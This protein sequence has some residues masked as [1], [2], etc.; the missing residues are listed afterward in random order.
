[1]GGR[2]TYR[3]LSR[4]RAPFQIG[5]HRW[6]H[7][8]K[9]PRRRWISHTYPVWLWGCS[10]L[11]IPSPGPVLHGTKWLLWRPH[12][13]S[14]TFHSWRRIDKGL[15]KRGSTIDHW[16]PRCKG[17]ILWPTPYT[18]ISA[19][20]HT[21]IACRQRLQLF[22]YGW[23]TWPLTL[24]KRPNSD[25]NIWMFNAENRNLWKRGGNHTERSFII[26]NLHIILL[27]IIS[28]MKYTPT[29]FQI[30]IMRNVMIHMY[31]MCSVHIIYIRMSI[32]F[33]TISHKR[34]SINGGNDARAM[35]RRRGAI[36]CLA[37]A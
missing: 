5:I 27:N 34:G 8:R 7:L 4:K 37:S 10:W 29:L 32:L 13:Q 1:M 26:C 3:T 19:Y 2:T 31:S 12:K 20:I 23:E 36:L 9:V 35:T 33:K 11:K 28:D 22:Q 6:P 18:Y 24:T 21:Y 15:T 30:T 14:P 25:E 16:R 17:W